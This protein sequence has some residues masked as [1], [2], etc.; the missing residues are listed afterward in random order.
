[1]SIIQNHFFFFFIMPLS[2]KAIAKKKQY[3]KEYAKNNL[4]RIPLDVQIEKYEEIKK[5]SEEAGETVNGYIKKAIDNRLYG[6]D[7]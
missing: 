2:E 3:I 7:N 1:M 4:K 6:V 5:A